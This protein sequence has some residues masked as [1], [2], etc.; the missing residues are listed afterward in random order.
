MRRQTLLLVILVVVLAFSFVAVNPARADEW[1]KKYTVSGKP[2]V[3]VETNDGNVT[4][5][6]TGQKEVQAHVETLGWRIAENEVR[7]IES[8]TGDRIQLEVK[9]PSRMNWNWGGARH[10]LKIELR[11]PRQAGLAVK[12]GDGNVSVTSL[13]GSADIRTGDGNITLDAL[14]GE[15]H[16]ST[17]D[18]NI[19]GNNMDGRLIASTGDGHLRIEGRFELLDLHTGDGNIDARARA[20]SK[21]AANWTFRTGDGNVTLR[22]PAD[23]Q[24]DLDAHTGDGHITSAF[25]ITVSGEIGKTTLRGKINGGGASLIIRTGD[26]SIR[27][28]KL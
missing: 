7:I 14:K 6:T 20:G 4:V 10:S 11:L 1:N 2:S 25:P 18:G 12:T 9:I 22:L 13:V 8:Q 16:L 23:L 27:L 15:L 5:T 19:D 28:E 21:L 24:A 17:G 26:G 3:R